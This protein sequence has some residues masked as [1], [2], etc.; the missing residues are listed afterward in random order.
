MSTFKPFAMVMTFL[1]IL[2]LATVG[3][4]I[5]VKNGAK[6]V[7][8]DSMEGA[9]PGTDPLDRVPDVGDPW[10][11]RIIDG[12]LTST[13]RT[14]S[15]AYAP[16]PT[17]NTIRIDNQ[18]LSRIAV[19]SPGDVIHAFSELWRWQN[20]NSSSSFSVN[21][22]VVSIS[23][24]FGRRESR[25]ASAT[26]VDEAVAQTA[27][28]T[29][30]RPCVLDLADAF[31]AALEVGP[32]YRQAGNRYPLAPPRISTLLALEIQTTQNRTATDRDKSPGL[33]P[34]HVE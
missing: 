14:I 22:S 20:G 31:M 17:E 34:T 16:V 18:G 33:D 13:T 12:G 15:Y 19:L 5:Q 9:T 29:S 27:K 3:H 26:C 11:E 23:R 2:V 10:G 6:S 32:C 4:A 25:A 24:L 21:S 1:S 28:A 7:F 30:P 8:Y